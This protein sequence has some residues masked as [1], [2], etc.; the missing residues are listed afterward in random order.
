MCDYIAVTS[1]VLELHREYAHFRR[2]PK[3]R[4]LNPDEVQTTK[5]TVTESSS[6]DIADAEVTEAS[7]LDIAGVEV[8]KE[9]SDD[10]RNIDSDMLD[11]CDL[12][13]KIEIEED[14]IS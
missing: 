10:S 14:I 1:K 5:R 3:Q 7:S 12:Q 2:Q 11:T 8:K 13:T 9:N 6:L 4:P